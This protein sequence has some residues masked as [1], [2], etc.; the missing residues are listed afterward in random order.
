MININVETNL[1]E[2]EILDRFN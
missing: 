1:K 2:L